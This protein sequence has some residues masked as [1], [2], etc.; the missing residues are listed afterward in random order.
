[1]RSLNRPIDAPVVHREA[2][3]ARPDDS[4]NAHRPS[5]EADASTVSED[6]VPLWEV[7]KGLLPRSPTPAAVP[8]LW[9]YRTVR[10]Q[11]LASAERITAEEAERR[12][13]LLENPGHA[14]ELRIAATMHAGLQLLMPGE[15]ALPH[16]HSQSALR[17]IVE[18]AGA[19]TQVDGERVDMRPGDL[20][21]TPAFRW[22][23]HGNEGDEPVVWLD[24][25][26]LPLVRLLGTTFFQPNPATGAQVSPATDPDRLSAGAPGRV[27][28]ASNIIHYP[29]AARRDALQRIH[30]TEGSDPTHGVRQEYTDT[31]SGRPVMPTLST[32][33]QYLPG[34]FSG[35]PYRTTEALVFCAV[36]GE[37]RIE[38]PE[39]GRTLEWSAHD[40]FVVP[41]WVTHRHVT[42]TGGVLFAFSDGIAQQSLGLWREQILQ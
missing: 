8:H 31:R 5:A 3:V 19:Y 12:V 20:V 39:L 10:P 32:Y 25:L 9:P 34:G 24:G 16:R 33:L 18:G 17:F 4:P 35:R 28:A 42:A 27:A 37:G 7:M 38:L 40:L 30:R 22:H 36:E 15:Q 21:L 26:D 6:L 13:L 29:Y 1:M 14:G 23:E 11:L 41:G 2:A